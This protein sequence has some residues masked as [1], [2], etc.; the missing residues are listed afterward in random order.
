MV[1]HEA[2]ERLQPA[3]EVEL[4][5]RSLE[6]VV[7]VFA[8]VKIIP[9]IDSLNLA[10]GNSQVRGDESADS[11]AQQPRQPL[12]R[13]HSAVAYQAHGGLGPLLGIALGLRSPPI[14]TYASKSP[15]VNVAVAA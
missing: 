15:V 5:A 9:S 7:R 10:A 1:G 14:H 12:I 2:L 8:A 11:A 13:A 3:S 4:E 6:L